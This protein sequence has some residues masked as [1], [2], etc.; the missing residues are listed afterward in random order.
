MR[1]KDIVLLVGLAFAA[2]F[3]GGL[4]SSKYRYGGIALATE[5]YGDE[6]AERHYGEIRWQALKS[7]ID[8][9]IHRAK[10]PGGWLVAQ[11]DGI[12]FVPDA[13]HEW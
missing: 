5:Y 8:R 2:G 9:T 11:Q 10:V 1:R 7:S 6:S 13:R 12:T 3:L 4:F